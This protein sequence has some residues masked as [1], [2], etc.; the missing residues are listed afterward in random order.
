MTPKERDL[1]TKALSKT[2]FVLIFGAL[3]VEEYVGEILSAIAE[4]E[5]RFKESDYSGKRD[6]V[7]KDEMKCIRIRQAV[8]AARRN[9]GSV[10]MGNQ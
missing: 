3:N 5:A 6:G 9:N 2:S 10:G 1:A 4:S 8:N 7:T